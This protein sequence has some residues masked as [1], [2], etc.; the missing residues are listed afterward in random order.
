MQTFS[1]TSLGLDLGYTHVEWQEGFGKNHFVENVPAISIYLNKKLYDY[2]SAEIG[3]ED[4][5]KSS[6]NTTYSSNH[7]ALDI[8][9]T[10]PLTYFSSSR[11]SGYYGAVELGYPISRSF[12]GFV[13]LG[14]SVSI[15]KLETWPVRQGDVAK[16]KANSAR[17]VI[18]RVGLGFRNLITDHFGITAKVIWEKTSSL[19]VDFDGPQ[20]YKVRPGDTT[21]VTFGVYYQ[22]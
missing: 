17:K 4:T 14:C 3:M 18:P 11:L 1:K 12:D 7:R 22:F 13:S 2:L 10:T 16:A 19:K 6:R 20:K 5:T 15:L 8:P 21:K 9:Y